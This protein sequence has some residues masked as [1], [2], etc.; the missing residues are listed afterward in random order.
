MT[1]VSLTVDKITFTFQNGDVDSCKGAE[2]TELENSMISGTGPMFNYNYDYSGCSKKIDIKGI[3]TPADTT[4]TDTGT[5]KTILQQKQWLESLV[6]GQQKPITIITKYE[7]DSVE[8]Q[9]GGILPNQ[10]DFTETECMVESMSFEEEAGNPQ[11]ITFNMSLAVGEA[12]VINIAY[13][14]KEDGYYILL[15]NGDRIII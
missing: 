12:I 8:R 1:N 14:L 4:R 11:Q 5:I 3:L 10:A 9:L 6:N 13:L 7:T 15:E 2:S